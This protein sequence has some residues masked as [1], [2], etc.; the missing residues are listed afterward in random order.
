[1][2]G[3]T[4]EKL[5]GKNK[6]EKLK[7]KSVEDGEYNIH[8]IIANRVKATIARRILNEISVGF[9]Y[10][11]DPK[12]YKDLMKALNSFRDKLYEVKLY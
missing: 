6:V 1:M 3:S 11:V 9:N 8:V 12:E 5:K 4:V 2:M 10:R 7:E